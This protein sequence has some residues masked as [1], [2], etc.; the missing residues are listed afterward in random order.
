MSESL[1]ESAVTALVLAVGRGDR[2]AGDPLVRSTQ[3]DIWRFLVYLVGH[4]DA[5]DLT[6]ETFVRALSS[7]HQFTGRHH[8]RA[9][10]LAI[11]RHVAAD[12]FR[13]AACRPRTV[14]VPDWQASAERSR[15]HHLP[16]P[17]D[18]VALNL[19]VRTLPAARRAAFV[20]TQVVG[21]GYAE[22][23][24]LCGCP[25]GTIRSRVARAR[26]DLASVLAPAP[27]P[28]PAPPR[29]PALVAAS[30]VPTRGFDV[31]AAN[32]P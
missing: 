13:A 4:A 5:E 25:V 26:R 30:N 9:W 31:T 6:Q 27:R 19:A 3:R 12:H 28:R 17:D 8:A 21:L 20:L 15:A 29:R 16:G 23:A 32:V 7:A 18:T 24:E 11:A 22:A 1:G 10:L 14:S 2:S